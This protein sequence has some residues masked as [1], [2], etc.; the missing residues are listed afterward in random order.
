MRPL[1][2]VKCPLFP[3]DVRL[4]IDSWLVGNCTVRELVVIIKISRR[5]DKN[6]GDL[7]DGKSCM[8][9]LHYLEIRRQKTRMFTNTL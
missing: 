4:E 8:N 6:E 1:L 9:R 2:F 7:V 5:V 3:N